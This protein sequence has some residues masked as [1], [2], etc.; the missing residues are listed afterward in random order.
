MTGKHLLTTRKPDGCAMKPDGCA[1]YH[2]F[3]YE[4]I[5][6]SLKMGK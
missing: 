1:M 3:C 5:K 6:K 2:S 4:L